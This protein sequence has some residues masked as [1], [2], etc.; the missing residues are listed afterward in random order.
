MRKGLIIISV[1]LILL[2]VL[3]TALALAT[4]GFN[5]REMKNENYKSDIFTVSESF[6]DI[7]IDD[8]FGAF[9]VKLKKAAAEKAEISYTAP[10]KSEVVYEVK[11]GK[12]I[13]TCKDNIKFFE[14][15]FSFASETE[16]TLMI[17]DAIYNG[18]EIDT[19]S[20]DVKLN[21]ISAVSVDIDTSSGNASLN[22]VKTDSL[23]IE[24]SSGDVF[25]TE[26]KC[27][28]MDI[29]VS[30]G[31][32]TIRSSEASEKTEIQLSSGD[33]EI[34]SSSLGSFSHSSASGDA[35]ISDST[36]I[37]LTNKTSSGDIDL[38][39]VTV[40]GRLDI[41]T[42]SGE[43]DFSR[44]DA[45]EIYIDTSSG[46]VE[47]TLLSAKNFETH[48]GS[49]NVRVPAPD[50]SAGICRINTGSGDIEIRIIG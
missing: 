4:N 31:D 41:E 44:I 34:I 13:I 3:I 10:E 23:E 43:V 2:G 48:T 20:G 42:S 24:T 1:C 45:A 17:P 8:E 50:S 37:R 15:L 18:I 49:G 39:D 26:V 38:E 29:D 40:S 46:D 36:F 11:N 19:A 27:K 21:D 25:I 22:N 7:I 16:L 30:S 14:R 9:D 35:E 33:T 5:F 6:T 12:L 28:V 47:G 32:V